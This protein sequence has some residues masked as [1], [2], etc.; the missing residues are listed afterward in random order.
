N[1]LSISEASSINPIIEAFLKHEVDRYQKNKKSQYNP[2]IEA[3]TKSRSSAFSILYTNI[4][5][6]YSEEEVNAR[7][8][9][10]TDNLCQE[11]IKSTEETLKI[12]KQ[13]KDIEC[14]QIKIDIANWSTKLFELSLKKYIRDSTIYNFIYALEEKDGKS[15]SNNGVGV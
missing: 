2:T 3:E 15:Y 4:A 7:I 10:A 5:P 6:L 8:K 14:N 12:I 9:E 11:F 13:Q 1:P